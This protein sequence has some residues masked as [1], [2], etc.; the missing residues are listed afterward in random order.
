[1]NDRV[2]LPSYLLSPLSKV[3]NPEITSQ[4][5]LV[6]DSNSNRVRIYLNLL[7]LL[8]HGTIPVT[9]YNN[10]IAFR[11]TNRQFEMQGDLLKMITKK[12]YNVDCANF[13]DKKPMYD[14]ARELNFDVK[15]MGNKSTRDR[16]LW[17]SM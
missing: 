5:K 9:F 11:D 10:L 17:I 3:T 12:N 1:M 6:R 16:K 15:A 13:S 14:F 4:F 7:D 2:I 8:I